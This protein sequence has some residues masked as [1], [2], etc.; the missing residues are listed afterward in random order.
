VYPKVTAPELLRDIGIR[1][2][3]RGHPLHCF[4]VELVNTSIKTLPAATGY[5]SVSRG[6]ISVV[7]SVA[8]A[9]ASTEKRVLYVM[10]A[11]S[12]E[13]KL[14]AGVVHDCMCV[15]VDP[16]FQTVFQCFKEYKI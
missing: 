14:G 13:S 1:Q 9:I 7:K 10:Q 12:M 16:L 11:L 8:D 2:S 3:S 5:C 4:G 15:C 6:I